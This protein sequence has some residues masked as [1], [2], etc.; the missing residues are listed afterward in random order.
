MWAIYKREFKSYFHSFMG[1]LFIAIMLFFSG[2]Y[3]SAYNLYS[4]MPYF[5]YVM[6]AIVFVFMLAIPVLCMRI[7]AEERRNKTDQ[8]LL[9]SPVSVGGMVVGKYLAL[10]TILAI[11]IAINCLYPIIMTM[12]GSVPLGE[13][14]LS[15]LGFYLYGAASIAVCMLMSALTESQVIAA[16][17]GFAALFLGYMMSSITSIISTT[18]N[19]LTR[20]LNCYDLYTPFYDL[21]NGTLNVKSVVY[22]ISLIGL[23]L[24]LTVLSIQR[25]RYSM[26][27]KQLS[28]SAYST[29]RMALAIAIVVI[30]NIIMGELPAS[31]TSIDMTAQKLYS[32]TDQSKEF[33]GTLDRDVTI[34]VISAEDN[35][36]TTLKQT[37]ERFDDL[38]DRITVENVNP[39]V[40]PQFHL[41]YT[42]GNITSNSLIVVSDLRSTV[43]DYSEMYVTETSMDYTTYSYS[44]TTTGYDGEGQITS[45]LDYVTRE[46]MPKILLTDGHSELD[47]SSNFLQAL[48]KENVEYEDVNLLD[49]EAIPEDTACLVI[50]APVKDFAADDAQ[51]V[52]DYLDAG[53]KVIYITGFTDEETPNL[54]RILDY[55]GLGVADGLILEQDADN[56]YR[57]PYYVWPDMNVNAYTSGLYGEFYIFAPYAQGIVIADEN[58]TDITYDGFLTTSENSFTKEDVLQ[59][60][61]DFSKSEGDLEGPFYIGVEAVKTL[62]NGQATMVVY[63]CEQMFTDDA[64]SMVSGAN[65]QLFVNTV[66]SSVDHEVTVSVPVKRY[67]VSYLV[68]SQSDMVWWMIATTLILP[69][70]CLI[71]GFV[72]WFRRRKR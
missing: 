2:L 23:V 3:F 22:Y 60:L 10:L 30:V 4:G 51:K 47:F 8:L 46:D 28:F 66:S 13:A 53:G 32:L 21:Q 52:I 50:N 49:Y 31:W 64:N 15:I 41:Q 35:Q 54:D 69:L 16:V 29:G 17:L 58:A 20:I 42:D 63:G 6:S 67:E 71:T 25:R 43:V 59:N 5:A 18:G 19:L 34:Y 27:L 65:L 38:S 70:G 36:D 45:A 44:T 56:Y 55:M 72:I 33:V 1:L 24:Y 9:T 26:S 62:E 7:L 68:V 39:V 12:Y 61:Q 40:N 14:Y 57:V 48:D 37:L 11:P